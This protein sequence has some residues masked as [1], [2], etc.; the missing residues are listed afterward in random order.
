METSVSARTIGGPYP[1]R[2]SAITAA[3]EAS[4]SNRFW[5]SLRRDGASDRWMIT[6]YDPTSRSHRYRSTRTTDRKAA[7]LALQKFAAS[8]DIQPGAR[9][10][11]P[12]QPATVYFIAGETGAVKIGSARDVQKRLVDLQCGSPITLRVLATT[13]GGQKQEREYH[14]RFASSRLHGEW[15]ERTPALLAEITRLN[16][17]AGEVA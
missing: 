11:A 1:L 7:E 9:Y 8:T 14:R 6:W 3:V 12:R 17:I 10:V 4:A 16:T 2:S 5:L 13:G 15:F